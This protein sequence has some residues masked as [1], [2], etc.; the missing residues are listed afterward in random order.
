MMAGGVK[1]DSNEIF[2]N[3]AV[4]NRDQFG[5]EV[6]RNAAGDAAA[7]DFWSGT[8]RTCNDWTAGNGSVVGEIG[9]INTDGTLQIQ[10]YN[11]RCDVALPVLCVREPCRMPSFYCHRLCAHGLNHRA[12]AYSK[13]Y[14]PCLV[15]F[16][17][18]HATMT[19]YCEQGMCPTLVQH[20]AA[21]QEEEADDSSMLQTRRSV[22]SFAAT[23]SAT[24]QHTLGEKSPC[25]SEDGLC[26]ELCMSLPLFD[27]ASCQS[28]C[29]RRF[30]I[31][32]DTFLDKFCKHGLCDGALGEEA[33][34]NQDEDAE[35]ME[36]EASFLQVSLEQEL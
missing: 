2:E 33:A 26:A 36:E 28:R 15:N 19:K 10:I 35:N 16:E 23:S 12:G 27:S 14:Y 25:L 5:N 8:S 17:E 20:R 21:E 3:K 32:E 18:V 30:H 9:R 29:I 6:N 11:K 22:T 13:C 1:V 31:V 4:V 24:A 7:V 34:E